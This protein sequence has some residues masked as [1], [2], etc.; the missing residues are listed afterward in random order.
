[1]NMAQCIKKHGSSL[2]GGDLEEINGRVR[3]YKDEG[4][5]AQKANKM[6]IGDLIKE[7]LEE[8]EDLG[9][10]VKKKKPKLFEVSK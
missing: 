3:E 4:Y 9:K 5:E 6:T 8:K 7:A 10:Q 2:S 1:M